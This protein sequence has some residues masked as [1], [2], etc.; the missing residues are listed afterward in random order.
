MENETM[1]G[2]RW[3]N[4]NPFRQVQH[5]EERTG[6]HGGGA[7]LL[8]LSCGHLAVRRR[9]NPKP[10]RVTSMLMVLGTERLFRRL[11][12]PERVRCLACGSNRERA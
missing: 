2:Y 12:A 11:R 1:A 7:W 3:T 8:T 5:I 9:P 4:L 10:L 6:S